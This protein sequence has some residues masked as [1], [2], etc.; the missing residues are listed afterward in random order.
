MERIIRKYS[1]VFPEEQIRAYLEGGDSE[2]AT[3]LALTAA[4]KGYSNEFM[5]DAMV[6]YQAK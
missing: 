5:A 3:S 4:K 6:Y 2:A 1:E